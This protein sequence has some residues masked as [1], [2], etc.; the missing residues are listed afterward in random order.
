VCHVYHFVF[1]SLSLTLLL[2]PIALHNDMCRFQLFLWLMKKLSRILW[3]VILVILSGI[4]WSMK[5][6]LNSERFFGVFGSVVIFRLYFLL[7]ELWVG[8]DGCIFLYELDRF[9]PQARWTYLVSVVYTCL[10]VLSLLYYFAT[11]GTGI[12]LWTVYTFARTPSDF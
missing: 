1:F 3:S 11:L 9:L 4:N 6:M 8:N 7:I 5:G 2:S 12:F 10:T